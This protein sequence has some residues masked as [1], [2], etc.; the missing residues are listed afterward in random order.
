MNMN[1]NMHASRTAIQVCAHVHFGP[2]EPSNK[3]RYA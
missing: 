3:V 1:M 2:N